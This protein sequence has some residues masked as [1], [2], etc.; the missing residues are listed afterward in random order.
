M[1]EVKKTI[2]ARG[3][4]CDVIP[5]DVR[6]AEEAENVRRLIGHVDVLINN[7]G[8]G[9]FETAADSSLDDMKAMKE[10]CFDRTGINRCHSYT[11]TGQL[12][13]QRIGI[14]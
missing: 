8:F 4:Q 1:Q 11:R 10:V 14:P 13:P 12:K 3:G 9:I 5:F 7:A 2:T 6:H